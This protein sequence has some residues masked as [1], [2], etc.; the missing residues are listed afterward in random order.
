MTQDDKA[1]FAQAW[2]AAWQVTGKTPA[3]DAVNLAFA[4]LQRFD[5]RQVLK[6]IADH[7]ADPERGRY[8][9]TPAD[10]VARLEST[11]R[12]L[13]AQY[14]PKVLETAARVGRYRAVM[15][16]DPAVNEAVRD[17]G[18]WAAICNSTAKDHPRMAREFAEAYG[19]HRGA[20]ENRPLV[21]EHHG[22][23]VAMVHL[24]N[25]SKSRVEAS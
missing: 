22:A 7:V 19:R 16:D 1:R 18:G 8:A 12:D 15:F 4:A 14:W 20:T 3:P 21:G 23:P 11:T 17:L 9:I 6:A 10:V 24:A 5:A 13:A 2:I 25:R